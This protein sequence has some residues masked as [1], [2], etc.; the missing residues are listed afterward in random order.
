DAG[1][2]VG[3]VA[4]LDAAT[5][6]QVHAH[7]AEVARDEVAA[8]GDP[9]AIRRPAREGEIALDP[10]PRVQ[11]LCVDDAADWSVDVVVGQ[12]L[13][14][15]Q[16][17]RAAHIELAERREVAERDP[18]ATGAVLAA[19]PIEDRRPRPAPAALIGARA[20]TGR[21]G[22]EVI[23]ALP[24]VLL[25]EHGARRGE[26]RVERAQAAFARPLVLVV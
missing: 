12:A 18:L 20:A 25:A 16:G 17:T 10:A 7:P 6:R 22:H 24:A 23:R 14:Q 2:L 4:D 19:D 13:Q 21:A 9:K 8:G 15:R 11:E 3:D 26:P 1:E 5:G